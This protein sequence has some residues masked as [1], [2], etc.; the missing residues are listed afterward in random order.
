MCKVCT[1]LSNFYLGLVAQSDLWGNFAARV[2]RPHGVTIGVPV[3]GI[4]LTLIN[5]MHRGYHS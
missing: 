3:T 5:T 2:T 4:K 1:C